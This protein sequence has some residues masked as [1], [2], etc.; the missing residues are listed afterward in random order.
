MRACEYT[1]GSTCVFTL[2]PSGQEGQQG[3]RL[4]PRTLA[5]PIANLIS[6]KVLIEVFV[7]KL[8]PAQISQL[9]LHYY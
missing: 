4:E 1:G 6:Q 2:I 7:Q 9:V 3:R 8:N 5:R